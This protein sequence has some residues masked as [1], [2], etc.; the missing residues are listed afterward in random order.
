[1][2]ETTN[3]SVKDRS[4]LKNRRVGGLWVRE[5]GATGEKLLSMDI[6]I[7]GKKMSLFGLKR[8]VF[9]DENPENNRPNYEI[10]LSEETYQE[11]G[12]ANK[13]NVKEKQEAS[14]I[15]V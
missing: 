11:L 14:D 9:E 10:F 2:S 13:E 7:K 12:L 5:K 6:T 15:D 4:P 1:M 3:K 8:R